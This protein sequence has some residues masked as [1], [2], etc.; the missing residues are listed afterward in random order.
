MNIR[1]L[2]AVGAL[3]GAICLATAS[4]TTIN[5]Q[6]GSDT[7][8]GYGADSGRDTGIYWNFYNQPSHQR[9]LDLKDNSGVKTSAL[10]WVTYQSTFQG[11][12]PPTWNGKGRNDGHLLGSGLYGPIELNIQSLPAKTYDVYAYVCNKSNEPTT[13][14]LTHADGSSV[15]KPSPV[16]DDKEFRLNENYVV[17]SNITPRQYG[18]LILKVEG[19]WAGLNGIQFIETTPAPPQTPIVRVRSKDGTVTARN[20]RVALHGTARSDAGLRAV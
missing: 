9:M 10:I 7:Y 6:F 2:P 11:G 1:R 15:L 16:N 4:A 3:F 17:F 18:R 14:T 5:V 13:V 19:G 20:P 12:P 8:I